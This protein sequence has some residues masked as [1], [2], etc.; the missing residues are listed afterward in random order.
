[1]SGAVAAHAAYNGSGTQ[2]L[3]VTNTA[4]TK[5]ATATTAAVLSSEVESAYYN[6]NDITKHTLHGSSLIEVQSSGASTLGFGSERIFTVNNDI[7]CLGE[8][9]LQIGAD[10][11]TYGVDVTTSGLSTTAVTV[12]TGAAAQSEADATGTAV[13]ILAVPA[14]FSMY[15]LIERVDIEVG[16]QIWQT[17]EREDIRVVNST[18]LDPSAFAESA[19]LTSPNLNGRGNV[20]R[21]QLFD[22]SDTS[23]VN[24]PVTGA[25]AWIVIPGFTKTIAPKLPKYSQQAQDGYPM[26][27]AA[28][29]TFKVRVK[30][31]DALPT[32]LTTAAVATFT[33]DD[34]LEV[35]NAA[36]S[37]VSGIKAFKNSRFQINEDVP[38]YVMQNNMASH[39]TA[40]L[41]LPSF[42]LTKNGTAAINTCRLFAKQIVMCNA[43]RTSI[44][45]MPYPKR[46]KMT[47]NAFLSDVGGSNQKTIDL[48]TFSLF[49]SHLIITGN[50]GNGVG[51]KS[52]EL[53]LNSSSYSSVL[54]SALLDAQTAESMGLYAN[55]FLFPGDEGGGYDDVSSAGNSAAGA[56]TSGQ[57]KEYRAHNGFGTYVFPLASRAYG[58]SSVPLNRFD[59]IR[60]TLTFTGPA[61]SSPHTFI[62]VTCCGQTVANFL[63]NNV[64]LAMY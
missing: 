34:P 56:V 62:N 44:K 21:A 49:A 20:T 8:M 7:D 64:S 37:G 52:V 25:M 19:A 57:I 32:T 27:A 5:A 47:Q 30:F 38:Y 13:K 54:P 31:R 36:T 14:P 11:P 17:L 39:T 35:V 12:A 53:K 29:N 45:S 51:L 40:A 59:A 1:M 43:E 4:V 15:D 33:P 58:A 16:N 60:L 55:K 3:S 50:V 2:G 23:D 6:K 46:I 63:N 18:E 48:D 61:V 26:A 28:F 9:Y 42:T 41:S 24:K 10:F 22:D